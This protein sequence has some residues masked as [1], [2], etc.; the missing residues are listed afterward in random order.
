MTDPTNYSTPS[1]SRKAKAEAE[2]EKPERPKLESVVEKGG[3]VAKKR[4]LGKKLADV[5]TGDDAKSV[6]HYVVIDVIVP[7]VKNL[8]ADSATAF[9]E[10]TLFGNVSG[11][12]R[13][14]QR[15]ANVIN[16]SNLSKQNSTV[17][18]EGNRRPQLS[19]IARATHNFDDIIISDRG[20]AE[21]VLDQLRRTIEDYDW[22]SV[23]DLY[24]LVDI[25][26]SHVDIKYGWADLSEAKVIPV[27]GGGYLIDLP[28]TELFK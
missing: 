12:P 16:Y 13:L 17:P 25:T 26:G 28:T 7:A 15:G 6:G 10:R 22:V 24:D 19:N 3:A 14:Q 21:M 11:R 20:Q 1:N 27:R 23:S 18:R 8:V 9:I 2:E 4:G 5:F